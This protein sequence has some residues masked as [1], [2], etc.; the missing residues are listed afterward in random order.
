MER[1]SMETKL[2][3]ENPEF[4]EN[5]IILHSC[6]QSP[7]HVRT[8]TFI[9][10]DF[11]E[12]FSRPLSTPFSHSLDFLSPLLFSYFPGFSCFVFKYIK[13]TLPQDQDEI[14]KFYYLG[15]V[16][17]QGTFSTVKFAVERATNTNCAI[18]II[19]KNRIASNQHACRQVE[20]EISILKA[21]HHPN[22]IQYKGLFWGKN[23]LYLILELAS[24]G[25]LFDKVANDGPVRPQEDFFRSFICYPLFLFDLELFYLS[26]FPFSLF[27]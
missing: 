13:G 25:D 4:W 18:K 10:N 22:I 15:D 3:R 21:V 11:L 2:G 16:I 23:D 17:G 27:S 24:G 9:V 5:Q 20:E 8:S 7:T 14:N 19:N 26:F 12:S 1:L 6:R